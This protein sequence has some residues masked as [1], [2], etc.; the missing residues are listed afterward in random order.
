[1]LY[2]SPLFLAQHDRIKEC[3]FVLNDMK[4]KNKGVSW[5]T[6]LTGDLDRIEK[7]QAAE[8][9]EINAN[10]GA[11]E[12]GGAMLESG[13]GTSGGTA[14]EGAHNS[15]FGG[16]NSSGRGNGSRGNNSRGSSS[17]YNNRSSS[18]SS[19]S[20]PNNFRGSDGNNNNGNNNND[21]GIMNTSVLSDGV[22]SDGTAS[23]YTGSSGETGAFLGETGGGSGEMSDPIQKLNLMNVQT[24][25]IVSG[26]EGTISDGSL[27][28]KKENKLVLL[29]FTIYYYN[30]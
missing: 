10:A 6:W 27:K 3:Y 1:M 2:E 26:G 30:Y 5:L 24:A 12:T 22:N 11:G 8:N 16:G 9:A 15:Q 7:D 29:V 23:S 20:Y 17:S 18:S 19:S 28:F 14:T 21:G 13:M 25:N 4:R